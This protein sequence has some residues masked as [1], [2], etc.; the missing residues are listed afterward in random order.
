VTFGRHL[1]RIITV[2]LKKTNAIAEDVNSRIQRMK[3]RAC[4]YRNRGSFRTA[5]MF[6]CGKL[7]LYPSHACR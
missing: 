1:D 2:V 3:K 5:I 7:D 4:G 6:H